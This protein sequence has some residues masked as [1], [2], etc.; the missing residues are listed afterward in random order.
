MHFL[1]FARVAQAT[2]SRSFLYSL[3]I[4]ALLSAKLLHVFSH[5]PPTPIVLFVLYFPTFLTPDIFVIF[6]SR[7]IFQR[8]RILAFLLCII[9]TFGATAQIGL[10]VETGAELRWTMLGRI[11]QEAKGFVGMLLTGLRNTSM[12]LAVLAVVAYFLTPFLYDTAYRITNTCFSAI[13]PRLARRTRRTQDNYNLLS[14]ED[15]G[16]DEAIKT[17]PQRE[18]FS[19][20]WVRIKLIAVAAI[21]IILHSIRPNIPFNHMTTTLPFTM[22]D[23]IFSKRS[24]MCDPSPTDGPVHFPLGYL[25]SENLWVRPTPESRNRG[26][27]PGTYWW[28]VTR[29]RPSWLPQEEAPGFAKWYRGSSFQVPAQ[30]DLQDQR[31]PSRHQYPHHHP[32]GYDSVIDPLKISNF[33]E[34]LLDELQKA[35]NKEN[36]RVDIRHVIILNLESTRKD[37]FPLTKDGRLH[38]EMEK[39]WKGYKKRDAPKRA[40]F[41]QLSVNAETITGEDTGFGREINRTHGGINVKGV[42]SASAFTLKSLLASHC[43]VNPLPVDFL[44]ELETEIYQPCLPQ[45]LKVLNAQKKA[46][47]AAED[48][49]KQG[50]WKSISM[51]A[52]TGGL[53]RQA[54]LME[55]MNFDEGIDREYL[56]KTNTIKGPEVNYLGY[57]E[58]ELKPYIRKALSD[59]EQN[60]ERLFLSHI[61]TSTHHPWSTP[62]D[63]G[64]HEDYFGDSRGGKSPF[65]RYLNTI[66]FEDQWVGDILDI[67]KDLGVADKTLVVVLGDHGFA[68]GD[69]TSS[70]TTTYANPHVSSFPIPL[71]FYHPQLPRV[72]LSAS[73]TQLSIVPTILD[74]LASTGSLDAP[75]NEVVQDLIPEYEG[76]SLIRRFIP[77]R[78]GRQVWGFNVVNPGGTHLSVISA[79]HPYRYVIPTCEP[80][81]FSFSNL[82][83]DP[84]E[85]HAVTDWEGISGKINEKVLKAYGEEAARWV[86]E[87]DKVGRWYLW[88]AR[89]RWG[90]WSGTRREDRGIEHLDDGYFKHDHWWD[91]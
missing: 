15:E 23:A 88:E 35:L 55:Y 31:A 90:Y 50:P 22:L 68:F 59:A 17:S 3:M 33:D 66:K 4:T 58:K 26:W 21:F 65:N 62:E 48:S 43:G 51:Q 71:S 91:T 11:S 72:S 27:M 44:E 52:G 9:I 60:G 13:F 6:A 38:Q 69:A 1:P 70:M 24:P 28:N 25:T 54:Q 30:E 34:P 75:D 46:K 77:T 45:I 19:P 7:F 79:A 67:I 29:E 73:I 82:E 87:A 57:S 53:D 85:A 83:L 63:F 49:W 40:D 8:S 14:F 81:Q 10:F 37:V 89:R 84:S 76:Q 56:Q 18:A 5:L 61:T 47:S 78:D 12:I 39:S 74:L 36:S 32:P 64:E 41:S 16:E 20:L 2:R 42:H 80:S 86:V